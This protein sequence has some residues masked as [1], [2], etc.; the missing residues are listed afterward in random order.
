MGY[1]RMNFDWDWAGAEKDLKKA[2]ELNPNSVLALDAY[3]NFLQ[4]VGDRP[5]EAV[6]LLKRALDIDPLS[7]GL[8]HDLGTTYLVSMARLI[9]QC[10]IIAGRWSWIG[11]FMPHAY[12]WPFLIS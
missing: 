6:E 8:H 3:T 5:E 1:A 10:L 2:V 7:P 4:I 11:T 9:G 12:F